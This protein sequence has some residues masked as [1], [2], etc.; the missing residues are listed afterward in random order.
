VCCW[1]ASYRQLSCRLHSVHV[2]FVRDLYLS[3]YRALIPYLISYTQSASTYRFKTPVYSYFYSWDAQ[4]TLCRAGRPSGALLHRL[5]RSC[6]DNAYSSIHS[7]FIFYSISI[8]RQPS[9]PHAYSAALNPL[10]IQTYHDSLPLRCPF[11]FTGRRFA[12]STSFQPL[13][14]PCHFS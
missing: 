4:M 1:F 10:F 14:S 8:P 7:Y 13:A 12:D 6:H 3:I 11:W 5:H 9:G 2:Y